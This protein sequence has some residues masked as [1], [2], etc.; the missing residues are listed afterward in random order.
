M[1]PSTLSTLRVHLRVHPRVHPS[2]SVA[3]HECDAERH[4]LHYRAERGN[5]QSGQN[6][7]CC[8]NARRTAKPISNVPNSHCCTRCAEGLRS[9]QRP[10][11]APAKA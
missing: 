8:T 7:P 1:P 3:R 2:V 6:Y 5:D 9:S 4:G 11:Q 10:I